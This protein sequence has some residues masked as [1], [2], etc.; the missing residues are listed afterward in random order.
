MEGFVVCPP[1]L[2]AITINPHLIKAPS[3]VEKAV[4]TYILC[5]KV[6]K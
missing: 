6:L 2:T 1:V 5:L 4:I 3:Y